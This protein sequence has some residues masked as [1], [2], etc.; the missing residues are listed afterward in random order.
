M[1]SETTKALWAARI[2][3]FD[4][5][6]AAL[7]ATQRSALDLY[8]RSDVLNMAPRADAN[9]VQRLETPTSAT[10]PLN[11]EVL[12]EVVGVYPEPT[13]VLRWLRSTFAGVGQ[14]FPHVSKD[15]PTMVAY[16]PDRTAALADKQVRTSM[17][18]LLR[19]FL[20]VV[21]DTEIARL[22]SQH[23]AEL[24]TSFLL[25]TTPAE[26]ETVYTDMR[27]DSGC[28]RHSKRHFGLSQYHPS[29]AYSGPGLGVAYIRS[30]DDVTARAVVFVNPADAADKRY[31]RIYGDQVL[32]RKLE[33]QGY[34]CAGLAG[35]RLAALKDSS[36][37]SAENLY[38]MPY[39]DPA[40]GYAATNVDRSMDSG[41]VV[42]YKGEDGL[43]MLSDDMAK[44]L[45]RANISVA[46]ARQQYGKLRIE[47]IDPAAFK[48]T[49][50]LSGEV[51]DRLSVATGWFLSEDG[52]VA[53]ARDSEITQFK[54]ARI[55]AR[56]NTDTFTHDYAD[57]VMVGED[58][59]MRTVTGS[60]AAGAKYCIP[61]YPSAYNN[62]YTRTHYNVCQ[63]DP[64]HYGEGQYT[65]RTEAFCT[66]GR[67]YLKKADVIHV[68]DADGNL[69]SQHVSLGKALRKQGYVSTA[70]VGRIKSLSHPDNPSLVTTV[71]GKRVMVGTH[72]VV[73]LYDGSY[74]YTA[75]TEQFT[76]MG[77]RFWAAKGTRGTLRLSRDTVA[78]SF[79]LT[80]RNELRLTAT[81]LDWVMQG[82]HTSGR[83][84]PTYYLAEGGLVE[85][86]YYNRCTLEQ[87]RG[88]VDKVLA[89]EATPEQLNAAVGHY[90]TSGALVWAHAARH[91]LDLYH[92]ELVRR[93]EANAVEA[94]AR[95]GEPTPQVVAAVA[96]V[97]NNTND[98]RF[99]AAA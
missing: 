99:A 37:S 59:R 51:T 65:A 62:E 81:V 45:S 77:R 79:L 36:W 3:S 2:T 50:A 94:P 76:L 84:T 68:F 35:A 53:Q 73:R 92:E 24:D 63:L 5:F 66:E 33:A 54:T 42:R 22:E 43:L 44:Q 18:K 31:V 6:E 89:L 70:V 13:S 14:Y 17:G 10:W 29:A 64:A 74:E 4:Q 60:V 15:D 40:G 72:K 7:S 23:R 82:L 87:V 55:K 78:Q 88:G 93:A 11:R 56:I 41:Y 1:A 71:G 90:N 97:W 80:N 9:N 32:K 75:S 61:G 38:V 46:C 34:R 91:L 26:I 58:G 69:L 67:T 48:Y 95:L 98:E 12:R 49:C 96:A 86:S 30:G 16:T 25:A 85:R 19:K 27:G 8:S 28:M 52:T 21:S 39:V 20:I 47:E 83:Y 57:L